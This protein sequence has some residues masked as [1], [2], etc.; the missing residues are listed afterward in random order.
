MSLRRSSATDRVVEITQPRRGDVLAWRVQISCTGAI[1]TLGHHL[2][3][4]SVHRIDDDHGRQLELPWPLRGAVDVLSAITRPA[5]NE[6]APIC[7]RFQ[8]V[9]HHQRLAVRVPSNADD[10]RT[11]L[12]TPLH[13]SCCVGECAAIG[14]PTAKELH[15]AAPRDACHADAVVPHCSNRPCDKHR[16][17]SNNTTVNDH[18]CYEYGANPGL[19]TGLPKCRLHMN[20]LCVCIVALTTPCCQP[21]MSCWTTTN[22]LTCNMGAT[23]GLVHHCLARSVTDSII[24]KL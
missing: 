14:G 21:A 9:I 12:A 15:A 23:A 3:A 10:M 19:H 16:E 18:M 6:A 20:V 24:P 2:A 7:V 1:V 8:R 11:R 5:D 22:Y 17:S 13:A 4:A